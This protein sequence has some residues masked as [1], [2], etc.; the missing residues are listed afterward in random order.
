MDNTILN[1]SEWSDPTRLEKPTP[2]VCVS[3]QGCA[4]NL[5]R[6]RDQLK[7]V[8]AKMTQEKEAMQ[9]QQRS[10]TLLLS[11]LQT[12][13]VHTHT[14]TN[15]HIIQHTQETHKHTHTE[16]LTNTRTQVHVNPRIQET[17]RYTVTA[18]NCSFRHRHV[19][20][21]CVCSPPW[22]AP[23]PTPGSV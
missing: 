8:E 23:R 13:Q 21:T 2:C 7:L 20:L 22:S 1:G 12:I 16:I 6:E 4:E 17:H 18:F 19:S 14:L 3:P 9:S 5:R 10:Q 11:N 15:T